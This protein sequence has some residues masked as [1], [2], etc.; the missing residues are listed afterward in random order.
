MIIISDLCARQTVIVRVC[1]SVPFCVILL[2]CLYVKLL[3]VFAFLRYQLAYHHM[4]HAH[5]S[6]HACIRTYTCTHTCLCGSV[7]ISV[8]MCSYIIMICLFLYDILVVLG[9]SGGGGGGNLHFTSKGFP[10]KKYL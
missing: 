5:T 1:G 4:L 2:A 7:S 8:A 6:T 9:R 10:L 3:C